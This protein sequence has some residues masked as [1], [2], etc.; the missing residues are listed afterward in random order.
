M[1]SFLFN[2]KN[3]IG[4]QSTTSLEVVS[5][6]QTLGQSTFYM[7]G[8]QLRII[9]NDQVRLV[10]GQL[11]DDDIEVLGRADWI[12]QLWG[13]LTKFKVTNHFSFRL[14]LALVRSNARTTKIRD[15][16]MW[17]HK[18]D[19]DMLFDGSMIARFA[20]NRWRPRS[21]RLSSDRLTLCSVT[22]S[23]EENRKCSAGTD[24]LR[25]SKSEMWSPYRF[26]VSY[27]RQRRH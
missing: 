19:D 20:N 27:S 10:R 4:V 16:D 9:Q 26:S 13:N 1:F 7:T 25:S 18:C 24:T 14:A 21:L 3:P 5:I 23:A 15:D 12:G 2:S 6:R 22:G 8:G 11:S 17:R